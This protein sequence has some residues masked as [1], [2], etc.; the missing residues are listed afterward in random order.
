MIYI[1]VAISVF[2]ITFIYCSLVIAKYSD[3]DWEG[4]K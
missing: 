1:I 4:D 2:L 3:N